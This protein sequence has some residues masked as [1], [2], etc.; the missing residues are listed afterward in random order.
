MFPAIVA[1]RSS[2]VGSP[3]MRDIGRSAR[4]RPAHAVGEADRGPSAAGV[5]VHLRAR[6]AMPDPG[7]PPGRPPRRRARRRRRPAAWDRRAPD[8][9]R[10]MAPSRPG[11]PLRTPTTVTSLRSTRRL[12]TG[13]GCPARPIQT[14]R[15]P[16]STRSTAR[17]GSST[18]LDASTT[19]SNVP[20]GRASGA[21]HVVEAERPREPAVAS[22]RATRWTSTP[23]ARAISATSSPMVPA[24]SDQQPLARRDVRRL[25]GAPGV[26]AGLDQ[27]A[28][29]VVHR[30]G[31]RDAAT[32]RG[33]RAARPGRRAIRAGCRPRSGPRT[34]AAARSG[35]VGSGRSRASCRP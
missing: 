26:A 28:R 14:T 30:V 10:S 3:T 8:A 7:D 16:G 11:E 20:A 4:V 15:R 13:L 1:S 9:Y 25:D 18:A 32:S 21:P 27:G 33:P 2:L 22:R 19:P 24:P 5:D 35:S 6:P 31:Q 34:G 23:R 29:R 17:A 12:S